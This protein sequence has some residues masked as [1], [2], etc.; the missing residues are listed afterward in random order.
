MPSP[1]V[2]IPFGGSS[3]L[4]VWVGVCLAAMGKEKKRTQ[5]YMGWEGS[6]SKRP[7]GRWNAHLPYKAPD[8]STKRISTTKRTRA[9]AVAWLNEK[10]A[11]RDGGA[12]IGGENPLLAD[13]LANWLAY[14]VKGYVAATTAKNYTYTTRN[15]LI[16]AIG[17]IKL[18]DLTPAHIER[19]YAQK[20]EAGLSLTTRKRIHTTLRKA[21]ARAYSQGAL[22]RNAADAVG[23]PK[24]QTKAED[25]EVKPFTEEEL[26][27][28]LEA[29]KG[30]RLHALYAFAPAT[31]LREQELLALRWPDLTLPESGRG[32]VR[33]ERAV[34]ETDSGFSVGPTKNKSSRRTV[35]FPASVVATMRDHRQRQLEE[36]LSAKS[37]ADET[38]VFPNAHG[39]LLNRYRLGYYW[40]PLREK[41]GLGKDRHFSDMRHTFATLL[42]Q[43]GFHPKIV[44]GLMGHSSIT[45]T[46]DTYSH[47]L[48]GAFPDAGDALG[49]LF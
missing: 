36:R 25:S 32:A 16:P 29:A 1:G 22:A 12:P 26:S 40:R 21:L 5:K 19:L 18:R 38:L 6:V 31:G 4:G 27:R 9:E 47:W 23:P 30:N 15:H 24:G 41:A 49:D 34:V 42:F 35:E 39:A 17:H 46:M 33:V 3:L 8:G 37:W 28:I 13:Y 10:R 48:E 2:F 14:S 11:E 44:Q 20:L 45:L 43:R 7:D